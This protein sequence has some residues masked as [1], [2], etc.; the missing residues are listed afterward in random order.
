[1]DALPKAVW[2]SWKRGTAF[3]GWLWQTAWAARA[4]AQA[5]V[6]H[7][8]SSEPAP[9][10]ALTE[11]DSEFSRLRASGQTTA[12]FLLARKTRKKEADKR[13]F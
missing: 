6:E 7:W 13:L 8:M 9:E 3:F 11:T 10:L 12:I 2:R 4:A 1:M 5:A